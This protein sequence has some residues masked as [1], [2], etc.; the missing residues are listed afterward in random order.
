MSDGRPVERDPASS[1]LWAWIAG[2]GLVAA[3]VLIGLNLLFGVSNPDATPSIPVSRVPD[4][5]SALLDLRDGDCVSQGIVDG[6]A[7]DLVV[8]D[9][10]IA[11][12]PWVRGWVGQQRV[13]Y[14]TLEAAVLALGGSEIAIG[15]QDI[16]FKTGP[17]NARSIVS[18]RTPLGRV[19][20]MP[21]DAAEH[22]DC[23]AGT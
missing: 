13:F 16:W 17:T 12:T 5:I 3:V 14:G 8:V 10:Q 23:E 1:R 21:K 18:L 4:P 2:T 22:I 6:P 19:V 9:A 7:P 15:P 11:V 20:W